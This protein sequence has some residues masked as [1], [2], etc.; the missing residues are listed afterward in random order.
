MG[1]PELHTEISEYRYEV[2]E[3]LSVVQ[4]AKK[5]AFSGT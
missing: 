2:V 3:N 5:I 1:C 4:S